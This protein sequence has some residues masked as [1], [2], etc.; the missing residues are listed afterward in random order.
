MKAYWIQIG[1]TFVIWGINSHPM[2]QYEK[3]S[4]KYNTIGI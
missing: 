2:W 1:V 3:D 4:I